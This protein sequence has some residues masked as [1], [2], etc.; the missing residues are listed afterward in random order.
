LII[1]FIQWFGIL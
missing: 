1:H